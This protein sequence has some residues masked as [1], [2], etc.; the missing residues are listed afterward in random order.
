MLL[1]KKLRSDKAKPRVRNSPIVIL[2]VFVIVKFFFELI[3]I[4]NVDQIC[5]Q[6]AITILS[7][8]NFKSLEKRRN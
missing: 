8:V 5:D 7:Y 1:I 6:I 4:V 2:I 3:V